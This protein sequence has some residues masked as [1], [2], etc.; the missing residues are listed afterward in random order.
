[1]VWLEISKRFL[2]DIFQFDINLNWGRCVFWLIATIFE[3]YKYIK[4]RTSPI[5]LT[6][7]AAVIMNS[8]MDNSWINNHVD[9]R[10][11]FFLS[12]LQGFVSMPIAIHISNF[13]IS[14]SLDSIIWGIMGIFLGKILEARIKKEE[15]GKEGEELKEV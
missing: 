9:L 11:F 7:T 10:L 5:E 3:S 8:I 4:G 14:V 15:K 6:C 1:M 13:S 12:S 2:N